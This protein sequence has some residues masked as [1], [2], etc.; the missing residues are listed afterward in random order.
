MA[1]D[2]VIY[3]HGKKVVAPETLLD[4]Y[5]E[6]KIVV[7]TVKYGLEIYGQFVQMG[8]DISRCIFNTRKM[9]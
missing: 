2:N 3:F 7:P 4:I 9:V 1:V 6:Y 8:I 5:R